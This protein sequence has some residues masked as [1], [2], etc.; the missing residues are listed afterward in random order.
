VVAFTA[1]YHLVV[2]P[3]AFVAAAST[4]TLRIVAV[5]RDWHAQLPVP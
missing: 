3:I 1:R 5:R 2:T 4:M